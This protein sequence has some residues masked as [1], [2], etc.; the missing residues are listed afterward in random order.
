VSKFHADLK[1]G[2][3]LAKSLEG[4][5]KAVPHRIWQP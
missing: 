5:D 4:L 3:G 1:A 2:E